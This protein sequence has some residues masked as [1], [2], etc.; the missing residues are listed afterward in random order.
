MLYRN[1]ENNEAMALTHSAEGREIK[2]S[3]SIK[4]MEK[5]KWNYI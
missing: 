2:A 4:E 1:S 5:R 3:G